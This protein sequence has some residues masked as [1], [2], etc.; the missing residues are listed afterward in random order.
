MRIKLFLTDLILDAQR[1]GLGRVRVRGGP[2]HKARVIHCFSLLQALGC[3]VEEL[4]V[5]VESWNNLTQTMGDDS[6]S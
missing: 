3:D 1:R 4:E 2:V 5:V 6:E